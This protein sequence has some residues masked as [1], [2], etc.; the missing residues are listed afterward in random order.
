MLLPCHK[1]S[2]DAH[3]RSKQHRESNIFLLHHDQH[4]LEFIPAINVFH[5]VKDG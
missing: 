2:A 5:L 4:R 3:T 1:K